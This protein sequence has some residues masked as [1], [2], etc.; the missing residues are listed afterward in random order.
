MDV[1]SLNRLLTEC[2]GIPDGPL[3]RTAPGSH[4]L[5]FVAPRHDR[6]FHITVRESRPQE[7]REVI[8]EFLRFESML[9]GP[10]AAICR[11]NLLSSDGCFCVP[12][13]GYLV[14]AR[15]H[16]GSPIGNDAEISTIV[17]AAVTHGNALD[18]RNR[19]RMDR[20]RHLRFQPPD[21]AIRSIRKR[22]QAFVA[23]HVDP[24]H[25]D[26]FLTT[27]SKVEG[28]VLT[29]GGLRLVHGDLALS[30]LIDVNGAVN[31]IDHECLHIN[32]ALFDLAHLM[33]TVV[34]NG[35]FFGDFLMARAFE[36]VKC[37]RTAVPRVDLVEFSDVCK[38]VVLKKLALVQQAK[39]LHGTDRAKTILQ[40]DRLLERVR[41]DKCTHVDRRV[42]GEH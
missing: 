18:S 22:L 35:Y 17:A 32:H 41:A 25:L 3:H 7:P 28:S 6:C 38:F 5:H 21:D 36:F 15:A 26:V 23:M 12:L 40:L 19:P 31:V 1:A 10:T 42:N 16:L 24:E 39:N 13:K 4:N 37:M 30:N 27:L 29:R 11:T 20:P 14:S 8:E 2:F 34:L 33:L 9:R